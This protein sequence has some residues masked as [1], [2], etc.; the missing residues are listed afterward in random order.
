MPGDFWADMLID[1]DAKGKPLRCRIAKGNLKNE[2]G[3]WF[4]NA[5]MKD[6]EYEPVLQDG[7]AVTGTVKRQMRMPGKRRRDADAAARKRYL[8]AHPEEKACYR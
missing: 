7:V 6:G 3:F 1:L 2:L 8:A 4:C 5:M